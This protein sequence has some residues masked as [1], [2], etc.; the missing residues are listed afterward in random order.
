VLGVYNNSKKLLIEMLASV[1]RKKERKLG[2]QVS[3]LHFNGIF[4]LNQIHRRGKNIS[5]LRKKERCFYA[6]YG[7]LRVCQF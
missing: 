6:F 1:V 7:I 2:A 4:S 3:L 5:T